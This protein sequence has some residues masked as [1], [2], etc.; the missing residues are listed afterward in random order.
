MTKI[1]Y[2]SQLTTLE[3]AE[4]AAHDPVA[5]VPTA[6]IEQHGPHLPLSTDVTIGEGIIDAAAAE[7]A[8]RDAGRDVLRLPCL[9][10]GASLEHSHFPGTLSL[11]VEQMI[12]QIRAV[13]LAVAQTGIR[14]LLIF[15]SHGGN[16]AAI[17]AAAL[18]LRAA[19]RLLVAKVHYFRF[20]L[21]PDLPHASELSREIHGG[22]LETSMMLHLAPQ[23]VRHTG[24]VDR[25]L[26]GSDTP[27]QVPGRLD[28]EG[29]IGFAWMAEDLHPDGVAGNA[30]AADPALGAR[31]VHLY[32]RR[33]AESICA[34]ARFDLSLL[35]RRDR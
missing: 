5:L 4:I 7:L 28:P 1:Q 10:P 32:G 18:Q 12:V 8:E 9:A 19:A 3:L 24:L 14:R 21:P 16:V 17:D 2:W 35:D 34:V 25:P 27:L 11:G 23:A 15:N 6:A 26:T 20:A 30:A 22:A 31:L 13:G 29:E 33:L